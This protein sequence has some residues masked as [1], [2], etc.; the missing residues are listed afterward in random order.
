MA[1]KSDFKPLIDFL[2]T[3]EPSDPGRRLVLVG[4]RLWDP[5]FD[6]PFTERSAA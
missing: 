4:V 2:A 3:S 6:L 5:T 1:S